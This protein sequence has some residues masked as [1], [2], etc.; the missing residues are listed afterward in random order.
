MPVADWYYQ[1]FGILGG[2]RRELIEIPSSMQ[3]KNHQRKTVEG[4]SAGLLLIWYVAAHRDLYPVPLQPLTD[5]DPHRLFG[6][7]SNLLGAILTNQLPTQRLTGAYFV[8]LEVVLVIQYGWY[9]NQPSA[10]PDEKGESDPLLNSGTME[11]SADGG[12]E[13]G[14]GRSAGYGSINPKSLAIAVVFGML[15]VV[16]ARDASLEGRVGLTLNTSLCDA[17]PV[18]DESVRTVGSILA[19]A[20]GLLYF[21]SRCVWVIEQLLPRFLRSAKLKPCIPVSGYP[22]SSRTIVIGPQRLLV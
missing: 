5:V 4:L 12:I 1:R 7:V 20:S 2:T 19:W 9:R 14:R 8:I 13:R 6:D 11:E 3:I 15:C 22:K 21:F 17:Q 18:L 16:E 10:E